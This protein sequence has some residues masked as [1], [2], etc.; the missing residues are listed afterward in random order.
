[1]KLTDEQKKELAE[2]ISAW[3]DKPCPREEAGWPC[4]K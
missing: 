1:M 3:T 2:I 4:K